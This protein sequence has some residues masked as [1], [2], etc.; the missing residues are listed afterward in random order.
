MTTPFVTR[1][2]VGL[3]DV[4]YV[5]VLYFPRVAHLCCVALDEFFR[6]A[7]HTPWPE[8]IDVQNV[9]MPTVD[10]HVC[11]RR[12]LRFGDE[13]DVLVSVAE[14]GRTRAVFHYEMRRATDNELTSH[15]HHT[16]VFIRHDTWEP[17]PIPP[18]IREPLLPFVRPSDRPNDARP[19]T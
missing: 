13:F 15:C 11:Y 2:R 10:L 7:I 19:R 17:I 9:S 8:M 18:N 12:P 14:L 3:D 6:Q 1:M 5:Q 16:V 4:D